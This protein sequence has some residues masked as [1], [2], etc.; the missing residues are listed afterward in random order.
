[1]PLFDK[2]AATYDHWY[3]TPLGSVVLRIE[4][5]LIAKAAAPQAGEVALDLGCGTGTLTRWLAKRGLNTT[6]MDE[7]SEM[8]AIARENARRENL[9]I[10]WH[11]GDIHHLPFDPETFDLVICNVVLEFVRHPKQVISEALRVLKKNGR[12]VAGLLHKE[13]YWGRLYSQKGK[14]NAESVYA[15]A[16]FYSIPAVKSWH[17]ERLSSLDYGLYITPEQFENEKQAWELEQRLSQTLPVTHAGFIVAK[18]VKPSC[19]AIDIGN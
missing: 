6:G 17:P 4:Q 14:D 5:E 15:H 8:L 12:F 1:M 7:S 16:R 11:T 18:W 13:G 19:S 2:V 3:R 10:S 9:D